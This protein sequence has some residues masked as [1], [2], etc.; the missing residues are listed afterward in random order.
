MNVC[1]LEAESRRGVDPHDLCSDKEINHDDGQNLVLADTVVLSDAEEEGS[2]FD[3]KFNRWGTKVRRSKKT[4][5]LRSPFKCFRRK[6][7][8]NL[9]TPKIVV[10]LLATPSFVEAQN[11]SDSEV[12][13]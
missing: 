3:L 8:L 12:I 5:T 7:G 6:T 4:K 1:S 10:I 9:S 13:N 11:S 2:W